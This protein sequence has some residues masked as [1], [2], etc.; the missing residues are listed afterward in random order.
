MDGFAGIPGGRLETKADL[1][2][3]P[4]PYQLEVDL[5]GG[6]RS[7]ENNRVTIS[8]GTV[9]SETFVRIIDV[10]SVEI[11]KLT[12]DHAIH[13]PERDDDG[14]YM[15]TVRL[16]RVLD[17]DGDGIDDDV[18]ACET[19]ISDL[20]SSSTN[21]RAACRTRSRSRA[22]RLPTR[23]P[24]RRVNPTLRQRR[25]F[26]RR[27]CPPGTGSSIHAPQQAESGRC[28]RHAENPAITGPDVEAAATGRG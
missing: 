10:G 27:G 25:K 2:L 21:V 28:P 11:A 4:G 23:G 15:N 13:S 20:R 17:D 7:D 18:D 22:A 9:Y 19:L 1:L 8:L 14:P 6:V 3:T 5:G 12:I 24:E 26:P 16:L